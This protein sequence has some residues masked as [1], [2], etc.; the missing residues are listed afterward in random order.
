MTKRIIHNGTELQYRLSIKNVKNINIRIKSD[1]C[2]YVSANSTTDL[3]QIDDFIISKWDF[4]NRALQK[5]SVYRQSYTKQYFEEN[6]LRQYIME[7]CKLHFPY[8]QQ[9]GVEFPD[10]KFKKLKSR[11]G[12]CNI[13]T[14]VLTFNT[15][16]VYA[17]ENCVEYVV[18]HEY[19]H[20]LQPNHSKKFYAELEKVCP[21]WKNLRKTLKIIYI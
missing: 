16:L 4:I 10:I 15:M 11:W 9:F 19:T 13:R 12:S 14:N 3:K 2:V 20:F 7:L 21:D 17:P 6:S 8:F 1:G 5:F 18:L